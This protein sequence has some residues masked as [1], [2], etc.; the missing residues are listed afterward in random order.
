MPAEEH[1]TE[2]YGESVTIELVEPRNS[3]RVVDVE[4]QDGRLWRVVVTSQGEIDQIETTKRDGELADL[5]Q[6]DWLDDLFAQLARA[7]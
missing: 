2:I 1:A 3:K 5:E 7:A 4:H 6:P